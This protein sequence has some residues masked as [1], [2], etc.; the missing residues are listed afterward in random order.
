M[1][2]KKKNEKEKT[3]TYHH[4]PPPPPRLVITL[5]HVRL[6]EPEKNLCIGGLHATEKANQEAT[7]IFQTADSVNVTVQYKL[8]LRQIPAT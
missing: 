3:Q 1:Q 2:K 7:K 6:Q 4:H 8:Q 5:I